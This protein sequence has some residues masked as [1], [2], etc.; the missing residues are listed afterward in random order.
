MSIQI[1][2]KELAEHARRAGEQQGHRAFG[3]T[4]QTQAWLSQIEVIS[5][6]YRGR[7]EPL[8]IQITDYENGKKVEYEL[9]I[10]VGAL[11]STELFQIFNTLAQDLESNEFQQLSTDNL[12]AY[13]T[14]VSKTAALEKVYQK[15][16]KAL[17]AL[18]EAR[19]KAEEG[20]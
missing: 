5:T 4:L 10:P 7:E 17:K 3:D 9:E 2:T 6:A 16:Q 14:M 15:R 12:K 19:K 1:D 11:E 13:M 18:K 8:I 20:E